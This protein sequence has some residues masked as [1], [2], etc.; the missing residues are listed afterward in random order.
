MP[1]LEAR[2]RELEGGA[3]SVVG[4]VGWDFRFWGVEG[5]EDLSSLRASAV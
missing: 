3:S 5:V 4:W 1:N 2:S